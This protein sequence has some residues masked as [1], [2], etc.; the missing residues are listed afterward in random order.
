MPLWSQIF[1]FLNQN[2]TAQSGRDRLL[3]FIKFTSLQNTSIFL[4]LTL[5]DFAW[6]LE[7]FVKVASSFKI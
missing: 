1:F 2:V 5:K 6:G 4:N 7:N 3:K